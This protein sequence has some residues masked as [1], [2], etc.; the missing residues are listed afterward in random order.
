MAKFELKES[1]VE[2]NKL[3]S[4]QRRY[5]EQMYKEMANEVAQRAEYMKQK[6]GSYWLQYIELTKLSQELQNALRSVGGNELSIITS[7]MK[8][9]SE[10]VC[11]ASTIFANKVG[12]GITKAYMH[13]P[14]DIVESLLSGQLYE[15]NWTLSSAIWKDVKNK[16]KDIIKIVAKG[17]G[18]NKSAY[19]IAKDL[20]KFVDPKAR[21]DW[22][23]SKVYPGTSKKIDYNAQRLARTMVS[24][25]YQQSLERVCKNNPFVT[26]Y[27]WQAAMTE[28]TCEICAERD[29][30]FFAKGELPLDHPNGMCTFEAVIPDSMGQIADRLADWAHGT[31]DKA[32]DL[33]YQDMIS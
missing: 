26:G 32:I 17:V 6:G 5:I 11:E 33:W 3:Q 21:K 9:V 8:K 19:D 2:R 14:K 15:G 18:E 27:I 25:A 31:E 1:I 23:W 13:V 20:E 7:N 28:R 30:K 12:L 24:H 22:D 16:Q 4:R 29:G 10:S